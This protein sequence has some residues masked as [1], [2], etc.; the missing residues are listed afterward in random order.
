M[1]CPLE[2]TINLC[3]VHDNSLLMVRSGCGADAS[4]VLEQLCLQPM[5]IISSDTQ[6]SEVDTE[7]LTY[8]VKHISRPCQDNSTCHATQY[9]KTTTDE[10]DR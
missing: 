5:G 10:V 8:L 9:C 4:S 2:T 3:C 6:I 1:K 7:I